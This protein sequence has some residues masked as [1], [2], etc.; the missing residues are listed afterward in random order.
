VGKVIA[1]MTMSLDGF[2]ADAGGNVDRLYAD[3]ADL[4][5][6]PYM[7]A[8][9]AE[10]GAVIMGRK[11]F[12]MGDPDSYVGEYEFQVPIFVLTHHPPRTPPKQDDRLTFT[13]VQDGVAS[14]V[15]QARAAAGDKAVQ[16]VGGVNV[17]QQLLQLEAELVD[18][19]HIDVMPLFLGDGLR[20][21]ERA[22]LDRIDLETIGVESVGQR[23]GLRFRIVR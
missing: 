22:G 16:A 14:A 20:L 5:E 6:I 9:I 1:G 4:R 10:T 11:T 17:I 18:E 3:F 19:L 7:T 8:T 2:V 13:F 21:F 23:T 15:A 12:E